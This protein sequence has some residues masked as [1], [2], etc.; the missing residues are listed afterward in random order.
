MRKMILQGK[1]WEVRHLLKQ[2]Q[3]QFHY[4]NDWI[5]TMERLY[6]NKAPGRT[7]S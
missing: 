5:Q 6:K 7:L 4:V 1:A 2:Y 3:H